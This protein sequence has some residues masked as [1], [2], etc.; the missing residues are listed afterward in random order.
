MPKIPHNRPLETGGYRECNPAKDQPCEVTY[1][2]HNRKKG[3]LKIYPNGQKPVGFGTPQCPGFMRIP[4]D[5]DGYKTPTPSHLN[6][7]PKKVT[8]GKQ[9]EFEVPKRRF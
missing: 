5:P 3:C 1:C 8:S 9:I 2:Q 6:R 7:K 4:V